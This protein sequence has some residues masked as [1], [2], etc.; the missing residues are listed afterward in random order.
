LRIGGAKAITQIAHFLCTSFSIQRPRQYTQHVKK[1]E[2]TNIGRQGRYEMDQFYMMT[3]KNIIRAFGLPS[4]LNP[5]FLFHSNAEKSF[6][7]G[8]FLIFYN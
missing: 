4:I 2:T 6:L 8:T 7:Q 1:E 5:N 3:N